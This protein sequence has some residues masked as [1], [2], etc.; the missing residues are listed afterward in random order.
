MN[1]LI[2]ITGPMSSGKSTI[3]LKIKKANPEYVYIDVD[4]FRRNLFKNESYIYDLKKEIPIL[5][6]YKAIDSSI[7]NQYIYNDEETMKKYKDVLYT[8]LFHYLEEFKDKKVLVEWALLLNDH[9]EDKFDKIIYVDAKED[10][11]LARLKDSDL[12]ETDIKK[13]FK[14]QEIKHLEKYKSNHFM[15]ADNNKEVNMEE[16]NAFLSP[17]ECKFTLPNNEAK[18]IWEITHQCNYGCSYCMF[19]CNNKKIDNE[20]TKEECFHVIDEL[21]KN[22]FKHL[23]I[24]GGEPFI[25]KDI[26]EILEYASK[27]L[28]TDISTNASLLT[29]EKVEQLN[30]L[31]LKM[32]HVSLDGNKNEHES[33]RGVNT[34]ERTLRGLEALKNSKNKVRIGSVI[35]LN[36]ENDLENL[37][38]DSIKLHA[39]EII[40]S[41]MEPVSGQDRSLIK[42]KDNEYLSKEIDDLKEKYKEEIIVNYNFS[43]QPNYVHTC[44]AGEKFIYI[45][46]LGQ[47]SPCP[48]IHENNKNCISKTSLRD[49][50]FQEIMK[51]ENLKKFLVKKKQG[52]C[53]GKI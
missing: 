18:A 27:R 9:L 52:K 32:I 17:L 33:V 7:L 26:I 20:L 15:I 28:I 16:I 47:I 13:R 10:V 21:V 38:C 35:H 45:N 37:V 2:G 51:E 42:T 41:I 19:S 43:K 34:Y 31:K 3:A 25:R 4:T 1:N 39:D 11:R 46:N 29:K 23:K 49:S 36:N 8:Y 12:L 6:K 53:Y 40:F 22:N 48:W 14:L 5:K 50:S 24:T 30:K 44:P